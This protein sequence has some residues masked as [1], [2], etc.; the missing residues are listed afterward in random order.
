LV[1]RVCN[2]LAYVLLGLA[3]FREGR[4]DLPDSAIVRF[5]QTANLSRRG[6]RDGA[7]RKLAL[8]EGIERSSDVEHRADGA[9]CDLPP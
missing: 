6:R 5:G 7:R 1:T 8:G 9:L 4:A 3:A 2:K